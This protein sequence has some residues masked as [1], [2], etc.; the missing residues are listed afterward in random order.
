M[1]ERSFVAPEIRVEVLGV[2]FQAFIDPT[3]TR[4]VF[5]KI[6]ASRALKMPQTTVRRILESNDFKRLSGRH[7][8]FAKLY[9]TVNTR[10]I[11][12]V[13]QLDLVCLVQ[14]A[15]D[16]GY[17]VA[18]SMQEA[19]FAVL[20]QES[21]DKA[22]GIE[23]PRQ[24][25]LSRGASLRQRLEYLH[26]YQ[27]LRKVTFERGHGV[28]GLSKI[29]RQVSSLAVKDANRRREHDRNW[30]EKCSP[31]ETVKLA[32]GNAVSEKA[33]AASH[34]SSSLDINLELAA[35]RTKEIYEILEQPFP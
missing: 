8:P 7:S 13:T 19:S 32:I 11:A 24:T 12:V 35:R 3:Q 10:P 22:M 31:K 26:S 21:V 5:S 9:T 20:L 15:A 30:R 1:S 4:P 18:K 33:S 29:N 34:D 25:Y 16:R 14:I 23:R 2:E 27:E 6:G 17:P 28:R